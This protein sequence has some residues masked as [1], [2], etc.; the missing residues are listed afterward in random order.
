MKKKLGI[1]AEVAVYHPVQFLE[2]DKKVTAFLDLSLE[3]EKGGAKNQ[4]LVGHLTGFIQKNGLEAIK[5][6]PRFKD[7]YLTEILEK[8]LK[9]GID[10]ESLPPKV[11][12]LDLNKL[13]KL[14]DSESVYHPEDAYD[15]AANIYSSS[16]YSMFH[17]LEFNRKIV[18]SHVYE[19]RDS[20]REN[21]ILSYPLMI[22]TNIIDGIWKY[23]IID[24]QH[25][26]K[27]FELLGCPIRFT[28]YEKQSG[29]PITLYDI[30]RLVARVNNTA[31]KWSIHQYLKAWAS[32]NIEE[33]QAISSVYQKTRIPINVLLQAYS[34]KT[35]QRATVLFTAGEYTMA[36]REN[37]QN[38]VK[39]L[40]A[41]KQ[42]TV[43]STTVQSALLE[44]F[45][46][47][48]D[49][50]NERMKTAL[51]AAKNSW[52]IPD[53]QEKILSD[54]KKIYDEAA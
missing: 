29:E 10:L 38:Y 33:Y 43:R 20:I 6:L 31:R 47:T 24:G 7:E 32:L 48:P 40:V 22:Y 36:D 35:R 5:N 25:R 45:R 15:K 14:S 11:L 16:N 53:T 19:I 51:T 41:L 2:M 26:F 52:V 42:L 1:P 18:W 28:L 46:Q 54:L 27:A 12:D 17:Y 50:N 9:K 49:Y 8:C 30:V 13:K 21:G 44:L 4:L 34:G 37:G 23:W 3:T 39:H